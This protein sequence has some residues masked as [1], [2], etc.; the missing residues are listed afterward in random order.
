MLSEEK[1]KKKKWW[2]P[3]SSQDTT[4][5]L[6]PVMSSCGD[7]VSVY[8]NTLTF[9]FSIKVNDVTIKIQLVKCKN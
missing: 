4:L 6:Y 8:S 2:I 3:M 7:P 9:F 1:K 5:L